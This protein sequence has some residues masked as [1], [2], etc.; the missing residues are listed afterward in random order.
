[1]ESLFLIIILLFSIIIHEVA[2]GAVANY[3]GD[4]TAKY[5]GRLTLN[6]IYHLDFF[7]SFLLPLMLI[8]IGS[9]FLI[10]WAKP[11]PVNPYNLRHPKKDMGKIAIAGPAVN[12]SI[13][14]F[15]AFIIRFF[16][17][18]EGLF[19]IF[20]FIILIN[21][22]LAVFNMIPIPPLDGSKILFSFFPPSLQHIQT[23]M[24]QFSLFLFLGFLFLLFSETIPLFEAVSWIFNLMIGV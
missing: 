6:P 14:L 16:S 1:M 22:L 3:L 8:F 17:I 23:W 18:P 4:P 11:V 7:G 21:I 19:V 12:F 15:F 9:P 10:G 13:A 24:E 5:S 20:S 2:H